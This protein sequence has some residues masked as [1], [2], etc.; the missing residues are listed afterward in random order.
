MGAPPRASDGRGQG[1]PAKAQA[2]LRD[3]AG[4]LATPVERPRSF[5]GAVPPWFVKSVSVKRRK[6]AERAGPPLRSVNFGG[7]GSQ[8]SW[9]KPSAHHGVCCFFTHR[10]Y[11]SVC[12]CVCERER[13]GGQGSW[14]ESWKLPSK[15]FIW[16]WNASTT[17]RPSDELA[18]ESP[19][20]PV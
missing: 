18:L 16:Y 11:W 6:A 1:S 17:A 20:V 15:P 12:V 4:A 9:P 8:C 3:V 10:C 13:V 19:Q 14:L 2:G 7:A 5:C